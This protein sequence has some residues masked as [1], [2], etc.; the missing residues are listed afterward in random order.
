ME[1][2]G[3]EKVLETTYGKATVTHVVSG[4]AIA[5]ALRGHFLVDSA[6]RI[7]LLRPLSPQNAEHD[8]EKPTSSSDS[9]THFTTCFSDKR[10]RFRG[11]S[12]GT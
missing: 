8:I 12:Q 6:L 1:G 4:K 3:L 9:D 5:R 2:S 7:K 10:E 11:R